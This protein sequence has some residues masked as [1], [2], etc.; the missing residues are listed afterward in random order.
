MV[1]LNIE[2]CSSVWSQH[3]KDQIRTL[4]SVCYT[5]DQCRNTSSVPSMLEHLQWEFLESR[6]SKIQLT[7]LYTIINDLIDMPAD[8]Y[9]AKG[10]SMTRSAHTKKNSQ[11]R[12][13]TDSFKFNFPDTIPLWN[14]LPASDAEA[15]ILLTMLRAHLRSNSRRCGAVLSGTQGPGTATEGRSLYA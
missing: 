11:D 3:Q 14:Y 6:R 7:L 9:L 12:T 5:T 2:Y 13:F 1:R 4:R 15:S 10:A 8:E